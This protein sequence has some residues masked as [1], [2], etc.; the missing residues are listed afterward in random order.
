MTEAEAAKA[1]SRLVAKRKKL[2]KQIAEA[3]EALRAVCEHSWEWHQIAGN[4]RFCVK[5]GEEDLSCD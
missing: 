2:D 3:W 1:L 4:G 5:C